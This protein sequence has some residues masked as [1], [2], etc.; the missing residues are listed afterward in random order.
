MTI[1]SYY[2]ATK[3]WIEATSLNQATNL[4]GFYTDAIWLNDLWISNTINNNN[5]TDDN[6][7]VAI[8]GLSIDLQ[9]EKYLLSSGSNAMK[10]YVD[11]YSQLPQVIANRYSTYT[12]EDLVDYKLYSLEK[13]V[14]SMSLDTKITFNIDPNKLYILPKKHYIHIYCKNDNSINNK[15]KVYLKSLAINMGESPTIY[16]KNTCT[17]NLQRYDSTIID[18]CYIK[19]IYCYQGVPQNLPEFKE[20]GYKWP[21]EWKENTTEYTISA[22]FDT[23]F[24]AKWIDKGFYQ[25][26]GNKSAIPQ[27]DNE[28]KLI[29]GETYQATVNEHYKLQNWKIGGNIVCTA[30]VFSFQLV[31]EMLTDA[32]VLSLTAE[33][34]EK[35]YTIYLSARNEI[36]SFTKDQQLVFPDLDNLLCGQEVGSWYLNGKRYSVGAALPYE[37]GIAVPF[38]TGSGPFKI[39]GEQSFKYIQYNPLGFYTLAELAGDDTSIYAYQRTAQNG[40]TYTYSIYEIMD[41]ATFNN[42][43][44]GIG[45]NSPIYLNPLK[46]EEMIGAPLTNTY[47]KVLDEI[48]NSSSWQP[49]TGYLYKKTE[50]GIWQRLS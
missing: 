24:T 37:S 31:P 8:N 46:H 44:D 36:L 29:L 49:K 22:Y 20:R 35:T 23:D 30:N 4:V 34:E 42:Y 10:I 9:L 12:M 43:F 18:R 32:Q 40:A 26:E 11:I 48:D 25:L 16:S 47:V 13:E 50:Q 28:Y 1:Y 19:D 33:C 38:V 14:A 27:S 41:V 17:F 15:I 21:Y 3:K 6:Q 7:Y 45:F 5:L 39:D 2:Y